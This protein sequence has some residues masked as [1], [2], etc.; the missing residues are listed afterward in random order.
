V[1]IHKSV[2]V[3]EL[4]GD[5][6]LAAAPLKHELVCGNSLAIALH[7]RTAVSVRLQPNSDV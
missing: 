1:E 4:D 5:I 2:A 3:P 6:A 7:M